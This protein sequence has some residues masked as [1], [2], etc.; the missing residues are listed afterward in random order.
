M[1]ALRHLEMIGM[2][3]DFARDAVLT[4]ILARFR[5]RPP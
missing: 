2:F 3:L 5:P 4:G 1:L